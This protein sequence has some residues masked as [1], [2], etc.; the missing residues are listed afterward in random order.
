MKRLLLATYLT[1]F[2][3]LLMAQQ[4]TVHSL[5]M[6][7]PAATNPA[8]VGMDP[9]LNVIGHVRRQWVGLP[10]SPFS[11]YVQ[12]HMPLYVISSGVGLKLLND[13]LG[14]QRNL[15]LAAQYSYQLKLG[16]KTKLSFGLSAGYNQFTL[17]GAALRAPDGFYELGIDHQDNVLPAIKQ[18]AGAFELGAGLHLRW[19]DLDFGLSASALNQPSVSLL[20]SNPLKVTYERNYYAFLSYNL[21]LNDRLTLQPSVQIQADRVKLQAAYALT[22][23]YNDKFF[24]GISY[25]GYNKYSN[26]AVILI[27]GV[28]IAKNISLVYGYDITVS[29][30]RTAQS[31]SHELTLGYQLS[32]PIGA[33]RP[34]KV[35]FNPRWF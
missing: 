7:N 29:G 14:A 5:Y 11:Q 8:Y 35:I 10:G 4:P 34:P 32:R 26:D 22:L 33:G 3:S 30:L 27:A 24:G 12:A 9:S 25:R 6:F 19:N 28:K 1:L 16:A 23:A 18:R 21:K 13:Q 2:T 15:Q 20:A 31:G 17:D